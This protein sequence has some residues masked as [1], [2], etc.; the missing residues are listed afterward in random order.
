MG[1]ERDLVHFLTT[2][3]FIIE[4]V[5]NEVL[6]P[7][8]S[9]D[10]AEKA[11]E[12]V[13]RIKNRVKQ[14]PQSYDILICQLKEGGNHYRPIVKTLEEEYASHVTKGLYVYCTAWL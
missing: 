3:G 4:A 14:D 6:D 10:E 12:L 7:C 9:L 2:E 11:G 13:K 1:L 8:S 5:R